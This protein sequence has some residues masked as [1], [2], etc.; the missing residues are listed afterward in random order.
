MAQAFS[1]VANVQA[2]PTATNPPIPTKPTTTQKDEVSGQ[3]LRGPVPNAAGSLPFPLPPLSLPTGLGF[4]NF[5]GAPTSP[6]VPKPVATGSS[7]PESFLVAAINAGTTISGDLSKLIQDM[8][9]TS[10][11]A[12]APLIVE[13]IRKI[14]A[15]FGDAISHM[16]NAQPFGDLDAKGVVYALTG[17]VQMSQNVSDA[18]I[19][20]KG[21]FAQYSFLAPIRVGLLAIKNVADRFAMLLIG[22]IPTGGPSIG[23]LRT[24]FEDT[25]QRTISALSEPPKDSKSS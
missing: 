7:G 21:F 10:F 17:F 3:K 5:T 16:A 22:L 12:V 25:L 13:D 14:V 4:P 20:Q 1:N 19:G 2:S 18:L 8:S 6:S 9:S 23:L 11:P 24:G 15:N